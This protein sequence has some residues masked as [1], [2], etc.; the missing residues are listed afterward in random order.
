MAAA[1][2]EATPAPLP[3]EADE[4]SEPENPQTPL[5]ELVEAGGQAIGFLQRAPHLNPKMLRDFLANDTYPLMMEFMSQMDRYIMD[6]NDR[7][8]DVESGNYD[9]D[10]PVEYLDSE[11]SVGLMGF[12]GEF[13]RIS[14]KMVEW[15]K[16]KSD[17]DAL[18][19]LQL[20]IVSSPSL[21]AHLQEVMEA[22]EE[23]DEED[24]VE[25]YD[26]EPEGDE[27]ANVSEPEATSSPIEE[28]VIVQPHPVIVSDS[29]EDEPEATVTPDVEPVPS[30]N[31]EEKTNG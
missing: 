26:D 8:Q 31:E 23:E 29:P 27:A 20:L 7:L 11:F 9:D 13:L 3:N 17:N 14:G 1:P 12:F 5:F 2:T 10:E 21:M 22:S 6:L 24:D 4:V 19:T 18:A 16:E 25:D 30:D 15:A 28:P